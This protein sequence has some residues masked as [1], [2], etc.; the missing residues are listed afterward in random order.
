MRAIIKT[1]VTSNV[2]CSCTQSVKLSRDEEGE[3]D[4]DA[5][6][7]AA[8]VRG[9][10]D[11]AVADYVSL[12]VWLELC[13]RACGAADNVDAIRQVLSDV[14]PVPPTAAHSSHLLVHRIR[15]K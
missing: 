4:G 3:S 15:F 2:Y 12:D 9:L 10:F 14:F 7:R 11:R 13:Q 5:A 8:Y 1:T 6:E